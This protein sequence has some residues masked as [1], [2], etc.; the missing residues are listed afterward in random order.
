MFFSDNPNLFFSEVERQLNRGA[1]TPQLPNKKQ[2]TGSTSSSQSKKVDQAE[3]KQQLQP[4]LSTFGTGGSAKNPTPQHK[5]LHQEVL[6]SGPQGLL[7]SKSTIVQLRRSTNTKGKQA[8]TPPRRTRYFGKIICE[9]LKQI[10]RPKIFCFPAPSETAPTQ[11]L[12]I[13]LMMNTTVKV[14]S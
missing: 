14:L 1:P 12:T 8:P 10:V 11:T 7:S 9:I 4:M 6:T 2:R 13:T 5:Q 3:E